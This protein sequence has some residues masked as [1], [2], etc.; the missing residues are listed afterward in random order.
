MRYVPPSFAEL[1]S[2][3]EV[4]DFDHTILDHKVVD[5]DV[6]MDVVQVVH[7]FQGHEHLQRYIYYRELLSEG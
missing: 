3:A 1:S 4:D 2:K 6:S 5:L 7:L